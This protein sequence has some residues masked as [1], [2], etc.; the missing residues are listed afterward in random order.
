LKKINNPPA[1]GIILTPSDF[2]TD[3]AYNWD[4]SKLKDV[5]VIS[6]KELDDLNK[7][8]IKPHALF[9]SLYAKWKQKFGY[10]YTCISYPM[11]NP[12]TKR[13]FINEWIENNYFCGTGKDRR[14][15]YTKV[16]GKWVAE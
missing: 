2:S 10:G 6:N 5:R 4:Q 8:K 11:Y 12:Y 7:Y 3:S 14:F 16:N 13:M 1:D 9:D 15:V